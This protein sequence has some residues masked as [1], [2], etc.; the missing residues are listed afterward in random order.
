MSLL[1]NLVG[2]KYDKAGKRPRQ[3]R[4]IGGNI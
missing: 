4:V 1:N 2:E 3:L